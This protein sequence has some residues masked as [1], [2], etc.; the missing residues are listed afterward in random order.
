MVFDKVY[1]NLL[2]SLFPELCCLCQFPLLYQEALICINCRLDLA[3]LK[4]NVDHYTIVSDF[5]YGR[6]HF[7]CAFA[8][9][10][11]HK[12]GKNQQLIHSL[13]Y[14]NKPNLGVLLGKWFINN[15]S[16]SSLIHTVDM[17]IGV[18]IHKKR[19]QKR[20][21]NQINTFGRTIAATLNIPY[22]D[23]VL[24]KEH[25]SFSQTS[26]S[27]F[28]RWQDIKGLFSLNEGLPE[29]CRHVLLIDDV[30]TTGATIEACANVLLKQYKLNISIVCIAV[31]T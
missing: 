8:L 21:Y 26:K 5:F 19:L 16:S 2:N 14:R 25:N 13:K 1:K 18:P 20:G 17:I 28:E 3:P 27:R 4:T 24:K 12:K 30:I 22:S 11:F 29:T 9:F 7:T 31:V 10:S 15:L 23:T 6:I